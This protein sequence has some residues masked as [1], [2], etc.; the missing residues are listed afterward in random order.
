MLGKQEHIAFRERERERERGRE[1]GRGREREESRREE[2]RTSE[3]F[4]MLA[5]TK[6]FTSLTSLE[7]YWIS[8]L[9]RLWGRGGREDE[10]ERERD[11]RKEKVRGNMNF[12]LP[13]HIWHL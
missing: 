8:P 1:G 12:S 10:N 6:C 9:D 13:L 3:A 7:M 5:G 4:R 11:E 2:S